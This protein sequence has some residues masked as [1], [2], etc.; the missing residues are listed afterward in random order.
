M[1]YFNSKYLRC[2][3]WQS[4]WFTIYP[5]AQLVY[6]ITWCLLLTKT[7]VIVFR[8]LILDLFYHLEFMYFHTVPYSHS[9]VES[10]VVSW[11]LI[12]IQIDHTCVFNFA[13]NS[14]AYKSDIQH[15]TQLIV[16]FMYIDHLSC[17]VHVY[18]FWVICRY[19]KSIHFSL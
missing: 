3:M 7:I 10:W 13:C 8:S 18:H 9:F 15:C 14:C 4:G 2:E 5:K 1:L 16:V 19:F 6:C 11:T 17:F 12:C